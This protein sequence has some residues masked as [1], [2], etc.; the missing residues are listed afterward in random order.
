M[1]ENMTLRMT[2]AGWLAAFAL[3]SPRRAACR[4]RSARPV[5]NV[6]AAPSALQPDGRTAA[7]NSIELPPEAEAYATGEP[8][9][10][11]EAATAEP[12]A[13]TSGSASAAASPWR[14]VDSTLVQRHEAWYLNRPDYVQRMI[15]RSRLYLFHI[16]EEVERRGMPTEIALLPHD[17]ER[18]QPVGQL[19]HAGRRDVA[20]HSVHRA[21][22][23]PA[24]DLVV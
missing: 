14:K 12:E 22:V 23:R 8:L 9:I 19:A 24:A 5:V 7:P 10:E 13:A 6:S 17:R 20:I 15:E 4:R 2:L 18:L 3:G 1:T 21:Q 11:P 16:V